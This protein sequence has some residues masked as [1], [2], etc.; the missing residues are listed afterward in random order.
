MKKHGIIAATLLSLILISS[1]SFS[2]TALDFKKSNQNNL[3]KS[4]AGLPNIQVADH[5]VGQ[6]QLTVSNTGTFGNGFFSGKDPFT[7]RGVL[8]GIYPKGSGVQ[9]VFSG[10][11]WIGAVVE[12]DTLVSTG[13]DGWAAGNYEFKPE[14]GDAGRLKRRSLID[15]TSDDFEGAISEEDI[16]AVYTDTTIEGVDLDQIL[17]RPH[18][19]LN[20]KVVEASYA[21]SYP[22]AEDFVLFDYKIRNTGYN[23]L[24][25]VYMGIYQDADVGFAADMSSNN[26]YS[27]DICGFVHTIPE[28]LN[29]SFGEKC[30]YIDTVN[31]AWIADNNGDFDEPGKECPHITATRIV[32]TPSDKLEVSFNWWM[33]G[34]SG[35]DFGPREKPN[36]GKW[37]EDP[38]T[39]ENGQI[40]SPPGD[41]S[42]YYVLK[43][44]EFDFDQIFTAS[45]T[46]QDSLWKKPTSKDWAEMVSK[47]SD[48]R[49]L[50]SF[51]PFTIDPGQELPITFAYVAGEDFHI[52]DNNF[53]EN[54]EN[55]YNPVDYYS[56]L[57]F[58]DLAKNARWASWIYDNPGVDTDGD[59]YSGEYVVCCNESLTVCDTT[60]TTGDGVPD[61]AGA[62]PP[63]APVFWVNSG[64]GKLTIRFNGLHSETDP[65]GFLQRSTRGQ[66][67]LDFEGYRV[68]LSRDKRA[69]SYSM[70]TSFDVEDF[71]KW[72]WAGNEF[73]LSAKPL[74]LDTLKKMYDDPSTGFEFNP[75]NYPSH[76]PFEY[77]DSSFYF[78]PQDFN[79]ST[80]GVNTKIKKR[81]PDA[82]PPSTT[83]PEFANPDE[84]TDDGYLK[85]YEY[86]IEL[87]N[88]L[89]TVE[90][91]VNVT[92][93][94]F[95]SPVSGLP[96]LESAITLGAKN[97]YAQL[98][99]D[100]VDSTNA[101]IYIY[102]NPYRI[103]GNYR[104]VGFEGRKADQETL[105]DDRVRAVNFIN[106]PS[107]CMIRIFSIDGDLV[108]EIEHD[109][110][111]SDPTSTHSE[112]NL[113][114]RNT[115][116]AVSGL[117]YWTV[118]NMSTG[119]VEMGKLV[120]IM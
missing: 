10:A 111:A 95:G 119:E 110:D 101:K 80:Y 86:E 103:D 89:P 16:I 47:G 66:D 52:S 61:F 13:A 62:K 107:H 31:I 69:A 79:A 21:W 54:L 73:V 115:Q 24:E 112:W 77:M 32:R 50:L 67:S 11:F 19:P 99:S 40:G 87:P 105:A 97:A 44:Q 84:L 57:N 120:L 8:G 45:I 46:E 90:Y 41:R 49:Y 76:S 27:D 37:K 94:D 96:P 92:A 98:S 5:Q 14:V 109:K 1:S 85:Y 65:D 108:R 35:T 100:V 4:T 55:N 3:N 42:K 36:M 68:Y 88:L 2:R 116:L 18:K 30:T 28:T 25:E 59:E 83:D 29:T 104:K 9:Y 82:D 106:L 70:V 117:Y 91:W 64:I 38:R 7:G 26:L 20:I 74:T 114:T 15:P 17:N 12:R 78:V 53:K 22:Y 34:H 58:R 60:Y 102:P 33:G 6:L 48:T 56:G 63:P 93:F 23:T 75:Y 51:G 72:I 43:N 118:E 71:Q 113:I 39:F 81:F